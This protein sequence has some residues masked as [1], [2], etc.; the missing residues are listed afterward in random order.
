MTV[1][2]KNIIP[3][4][5]ATNAQASY[6]TATN[7]KALIDKFTATNVSGGAETIAV[8]LVI[9]GGSASAANKVLPAK[10]IQPGET[11]LCPEVVG[12]VLE[13]SGFISI[14]ASANSAIVISSTAREIT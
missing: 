3:R 4:Q 13:S 9:S 6:Y 11:Y 2:V 14:I 5:Y 12:Q 10:T 8:N 1:T 7:C